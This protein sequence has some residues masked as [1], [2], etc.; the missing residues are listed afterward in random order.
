MRKVAYLN[1]S[2]TVMTERRKHPRVPYGAWV[3]DTTEGGLGFYLALN[4]SLG[5]L[6]LRTTGEAPPLGNKVRLRLVIENERRVMAVDG[7]VVRHAPGGPGDFA[8]RFVDLDAGQREFL[9]A[10]IQE[11]V[12]AGDDTPD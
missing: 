3:E 7:E 4:M 5:G 9:R 8:V 12:A 10:L 2:S 6:M 11:A 1:V